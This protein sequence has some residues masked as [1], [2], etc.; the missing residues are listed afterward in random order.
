MFHRDWLWQAL[1][2]VSRTFWK[3]LWCLMVLGIAEMNEIF[4]PPLGFFLLFPGLSAYTC[5]LPDQWA[6]RIRVTWSLSPNQRPGI[7]HTPGLGS[8]GVPVHP[9]S[10]WPQHSV[11]LSWWAW[12]NIL[13]RNPY[14]AISTFYEN[15]IFLTTPAPLFSGKCNETPNTRPFFEH[16]QE[17]SF[18]PLKSP[19]KY[20][21]S[22]KKIGEKAEKSVWK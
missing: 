22:T 18:F 3:A 2:S 6:S 10:L 4:V 16:F 15:L 17:K 5:S 19:K 20:T 21:K 9:L 7:P 8:W 13:P 12:V 11:L 14:N 1:W